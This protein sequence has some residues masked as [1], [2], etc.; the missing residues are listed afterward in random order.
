MKVYMGVG[1]TNMYDMQLENASCM[2]SSGSPSIAFGTAASAL[3]LSGTGAGGSACCC[4]CR[5]PLEGWEALGWTWSLACFV[6]CE[7][8]LVSGPRV[9]G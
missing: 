8:L 4:G 2:Y 1:I 5:L 9:I 7:L 6:D 3:R